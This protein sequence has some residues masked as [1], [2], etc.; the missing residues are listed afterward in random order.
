MP[1]NFAGAVTNS[2]SSGEPAAERLPLTSEDTLAL[3]YEK[4]KALFPAAMADG[5]V[6]FE[7]LRALFS[8]ESTAGR[9]RYGLSWA[10]KSEA[11]RALRHLTTAT[12]LPAPS[13]SV[14]WD[15]TS[16]VIIEGDNLEVLKTLQ[17]AYHGKIKVIYIDPP[18][19]TGNEDLAYPD[20]FSEGLA[21]YQRYTQQINA[22]G[23]RTSTK[24]NK[25]GRYHSRWLTMMYP[26]LYL[27]R[28]LLR[29]DGVIFVSIDDHEVHNLRL[30]MD[31]IFGEENFLSVFV[32]RRRL[33][34]GMRENPLSPDHEY[35][36][37]FAKYAPMVHL[38]GRAK[39]ADDY[40][41]RDEKGVYRST[42]LTVG[43][44]R[45][46]R[47][48][49]FFAIKSPHTGAE[50][51][52]AEDRVWR[53]EPTSMQRQIVE[54]NIIWPDA[55]PNSKMSRPRF[56]TRFSE[57]GESS[58][59]IST[60]IA[61][62]SSEI[63]ENDDVEMARAGLNQE[64]T[65]QLRELFGEQVLEYPK[66]VSL[67]KFFVSASTR[68]DDVVLDF[69][70]GSGTTA[71]AVLDLNKEDGGSR[72]FILVQL[73]EPTE[74][75]DFPTIAEIT[76]E[77]VRRVIRQMENESNEELALHESGAKPD[78]GFKVFKLAASNFAVWDPALAPV[79]AEG[80]TTQWELTADNV[81][82]DAQEEA[83]LYELMLKCRLPLHSRFEK[84]KAADCTVYRL[85]Q[86]RQLFC[87]SREL[88]RE[89]IR[90]MIAFQPQA[91]LCLDIGFK[92]NDALKV[93]AQLECKTHG[94]EFRTV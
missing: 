54:Q 58:N 6:D 76:K 52:P 5:E 81:R 66:P 90:A 68:S 71:Q 38:Y 70:A 65:K 94:L 42:D 14:N 74:R 43:M 51:W 17:H 46:M 19:N 72:K 73:P 85:D 77:R 55:N 91:I 56:K 86:G 57:S 64:A 67:I 20:D 13:E 79:A 25:S 45:A 31:E 4:L 35:I 41:L 62:T 1:K 18:Y 3:N 61:S 33:A 30:V 47:P 23:H 39:K 9:E 40:P 7:K 69:F 63:D 49:Q 83:L 11:V 82:P 26:R 92:G 88:T 10:G 48:N 93:N 75:K 34:T 60:W 44:T 22:E 21:N 28:N 16:N 89:A 80:L 53:F 8:E 37:C 32:R 78:L 27:A 12:L 36:L 2:S 50:Y 59:P 29:E 15:T 87:L 84:E 24:V